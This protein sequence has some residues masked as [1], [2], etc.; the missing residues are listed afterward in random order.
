MEGIGDEDS[1]E[2]SLVRLCESNDDLTEGVERFSLNVPARSLGGVYRASDHLQRV[3]ILDKEYVKFGL[4]G[5]F[6][7]IV[8]DPESGRVLQAGKK[9]DETI[10]VNTSLEHF[11]ECI[12]IFVS[13]HSLCSVESD[14]DWERAAEELDR[15]VLQIDAE[16]HAAN[17][18]FWHDLKWDIANGDYS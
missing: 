14:D 5:L 6:G 7:I 3:S 10:L 4:T 16:A 11:N 18:G 12:R 2:F 13:L 8:L 9:M 17:G 15:A 1:V